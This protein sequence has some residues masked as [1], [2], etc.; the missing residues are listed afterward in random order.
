MLKT[1]WFEQVYLIKCPGL[2]QRLCECGCWAALE[3][4]VNLVLQV[5]DGCERPVAA[6]VTWVTSLLVESSRSVARGSE[7]HGQRPV[8]SHVQ[9]VKPERPVGLTPEPRDAVS[10]RLSDGRRRDGQRRGR[11]SLRV[12]PL[13]GLW[14]IELRFYWS[15]AG[16]VLTE[17]AVA[18]Q[19]VATIH[20]GGRFRG[21]GIRK[22][23][24]AA[25]SEMR[26]QH[27]PPLSCGGERAANGRAAPT[28]SRRAETHLA[29]AC[30]GLWEQ[31]RLAAQQV[32]C[33]IRA[34]VVVI[35]TGMVTHSNVGNLRNKPNSQI[36]Y[37]KYDKDYEAVFAAHLEQDGIGFGAEWIVRQEEKQRRTF[38][39]LLLQ[40]AGLS[41]RRLQPLEDGLMVLE[42]PAADG[43][44]REVTFQSREN[45]KAQK[46][47]FIN[48]KLIEY[49][50]SW[51]D[52]SAHQRGV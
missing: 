7:P 23:V 18:A 35:L 33:S 13:F 40:E 16:T 1:N 6:P 50:I 28:R 46:K 34:G 12:R 2:T 48:L 3:N 10:S 43:L 44:G 8:Q 31:N 19:E 37:L 26:L 27:V 5:H 25:V 45:L 36:R 11:E 15:A 20:W 21:H 14:L 51:L 39:Q 32:G 9:Q 24:E 17:R 52:H 42:H 29:H 4:V 49:R 38:S 30:P 41:A 22:S 47:H